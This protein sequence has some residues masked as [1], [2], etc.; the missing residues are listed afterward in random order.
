[1][2]GTNSAIYQYIFLNWTDLQFGI[3]HL[4]HVASYIPK[5]LQRP[6][7]YVPPRRCCGE[8][9]CKGDTILLSVNYV[10]EVLVFQQGNPVM[11]LISI[12]LQGESWGI[13]SSW[14]G[15]QAREV[16]RETFGIINNDLV[17]TFDIDVHE[18]LTNTRGS[19]LSLVRPSI[20]VSNPLLFILFYSFANTIWIVWCWHYAAGFSHTGW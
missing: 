18:T 7:H 17:G 9:I 3:C 12:T 14:K 4:H 19:A 20:C 10:Y 13:R 1:M 16:V 2:G 8:H 11:L 5:Y 15:I 6:F